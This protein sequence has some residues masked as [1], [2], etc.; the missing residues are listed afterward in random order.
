VFVEQS[1]NLKKKYDFENYVY[2]LSKPY[3]DWDVIGLMDSS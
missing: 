1:L 2:K 3:M